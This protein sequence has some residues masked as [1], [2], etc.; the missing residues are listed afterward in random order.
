MAPDEPD[1]YLDIGRLADD[2]RVS[3]TMD[4]PWLGIHFQCCE[5]YARVYRN[6]DGTLYFGRCPRC[7]RKVRLRVGSGGTDARFFR[8]T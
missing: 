3:P 8:A 1:F 4:R 6:R 5:V 7:L 2:R